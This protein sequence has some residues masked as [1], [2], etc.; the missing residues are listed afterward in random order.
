M[1][2]WS[3]L[4]SFSLQLPPTRPLLSLKAY[5]Q[6]RVSSQIGGRVEKTAAVLAHERLSIVDVD[7]ARASREDWAFENAADR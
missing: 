7:K 1:P 3:A 4:L 5:Q 2:K 6:T